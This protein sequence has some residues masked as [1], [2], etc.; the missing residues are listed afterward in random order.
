MLSEYQLNERE[1]G[2]NWDT[3]HQTHIA[4]NKNRF[5]LCNALAFFSPIPPTLHLAYSSNMKRAP[6]ISCGYPFSA[7]VYTIFSHYLFKIKYEPKKNRTFRSLR[8][9]SALFFL[10]FGL[11]VLL[12]CRCNEFSKASEKKN[13]LFALPG[14]FSFGI[15]RAARTFTK[16]PDDRKSE[17]MNEKEFFL[18][19]YS[20]NLMK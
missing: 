9:F 16:P 20:K 8:F 14:N 6:A 19:K 10:S 5:F 18:K 4:T 12:Y 13:I 3:Q 1:L 15:F 11:N 7:F 2:R 17:R